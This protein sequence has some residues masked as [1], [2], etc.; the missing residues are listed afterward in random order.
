MRLR[1]RINRC[2]RVL[3]ILGAVDQGTSAT[4][5]MSHGH[6]PTYWQQKAH[7][8]SHLAAILI[9]LRDY[10]KPFK[11][12]ASAGRSAAS[13]PSDETTRSALHHPQRTAANLALGR[14]YFR[15]VKVRCTRPSQL[16]SVST[17][18]TS[19]RPLQIGQS[20]NGLPDSEE[21]P[22]IGAILKCEPGSVE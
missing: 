18:G 7:I 17:C 10:C 6:A 19:H 22:S 9:D 16:A 11:A 4:R 2:Y 21:I 20:V 15:L 13:F 3:C 5:S 14:R 1:V 8:S 12:K